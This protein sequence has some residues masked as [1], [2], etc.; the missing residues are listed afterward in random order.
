[1]STLTAHARLTRSEARR[2][3]ASVPA[4]ASGRVADPTGLVRPMLEAVGL[5]VLSLI[6][7][8]FVTLSAGGTDENGDR[9]TPLSQ[10]TIDGRRVGRGEGVAQI[11]RDT[12]VLMNSLSPGGPGSLIE[13]L[14]NGVSVGTNVPYAHYQHF[15]TKTIPARPLWPERIPDSWS[16]EILDTVRQGVA[17]LCARLLGGA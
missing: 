3:L 7:Q 13:V 5:T 11:L 9:W 1:M 4:L 15:G 8:R 6:K 14:H 2:L 12:G 10:N 16:D 17:K